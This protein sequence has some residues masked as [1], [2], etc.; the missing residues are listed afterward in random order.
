[1]LLKPSRVVELVI[2][3]QAT[4]DTQVDEI[5]AGKYFKSWRG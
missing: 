4:D 1:M 5:H 2:L 3:Q